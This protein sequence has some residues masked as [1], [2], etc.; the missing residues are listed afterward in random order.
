MIFNSNTNTALI[1]YRGA[2]EHASNAVG[3]LANT[4]LVCFVCEEE[5]KSEPDSFVLYKCCGKHHVCHNHHK[6][7]DLVTNLELGRDGHT[8]LKCA[9]S[10]CKAD[11]IWP[12]QRLDPS[13]CAINKQV[14][15]TLP[16]LKDQAH[17]TEEFQ[18][19]CNKEY[20]T[21]LN[22]A[23]VRVAQ[24]ETGRTNAEN[25]LKEVKIALEQAE[26]AATEAAS[27]RKGPPKKAD[28][29]AKHG[30]DFWNEQQSNKKQ[31]ANERA[32]ERAEEA[33]INR[34][35][36]KLVQILSTKCADLMGQASYEAWLAEML[37]SRAGPS[38]EARAECAEC[39][40][41]G[42]SDGEM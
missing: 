33:E 25:E 19:E 31:R 37:E 14:C 2:N 23:D 10:C 30:I 9:H 26:A 12:V 5:G 16:A 22:R 38:S 24:A 8:T 4:I 21:V 17:A 11:A 36:S 27:I 42:N 13:A 1:K 6:S 28:V 32:E 29:V 35:N 18:K 20:A 41:S 39:D 3:K 40:E 7:K 15:K 34:H